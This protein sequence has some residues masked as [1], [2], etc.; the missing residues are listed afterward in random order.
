[1]DNNKRTITLE[2]IGEIASKYKIS[3]LIVRKRNGEEHYF[4]SELDSS[5]HSTIVKKEENSLSKSLFMG[6]DEDTMKM[7]FNQTLEE[8]K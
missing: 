6:D 5:T 3:A 1:M 8:V 4:G 7:A 2:K